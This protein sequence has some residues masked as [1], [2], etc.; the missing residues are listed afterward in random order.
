MKVFLDTVGCRLNQAEIESMAWQFRSYGH[1]VVPE[2]G[3]ADLVIVNTCTVTSKAASDSRGKSRQAARAGASKIVLTGCW[4]T[5]EPQ[6]ASTLPNVQ[7]V[8]MNNG[9]EY[10]VRDILDLPANSS[11]QE[12]HPREPLPGLRLRTRAFIKAQDGCDYRCSF[13]IT[14]VARGKGHS[15]PLNDI[16]FDISNALLGGTKEIVLTGVHLGSWGQDFNLH[17]S[18]LIKTILNTTDVPRLRLS[19]LEPWDLDMEFFSLWQDQRLCRH[20]HLPL[21]SGCEATLK[22]MNRKTTPGLYRKLLAN[23]RSSIPE[24]AITTDIIAGFPGETEEEFDET[25]NFI[26]EMNFAG[27]HVFSYSARPGT[28]AAQMSG[29]IPLALRK[30]RNA[31]LRAILQESAQIY[32][33][34]F[35]GKILPVL[36]ESTK[37]CEAGRWQLRG[38]TDNYLRLTTISPEERW[39]KIDRVCLT[40]LAEDGVEGEIVYE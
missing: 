21:Q 23:L 12:F 8:V 29:Q 15:R 2:P 25:I 17:L 30:I 19:S 3:Q 10:L 26:R 1:T 32:R 40:A 37:H 24:V 7:G 34:I 39:N 36:W 13:C 16:L 18:D 28:T 5:L 4:A 22:R 27:G 9:K 6:A 20:L 33:K 14:S 35:L 31:A 38:L 11:A